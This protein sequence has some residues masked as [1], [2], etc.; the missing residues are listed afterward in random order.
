MIETLEYDEVQQSVENSSAPCKDTCFGNLLPLNM[1]WNALVRW[2][3]VK[4]QGCE[5]KF[6]TYK[7]LVLPAKE[8]YLK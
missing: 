3:S 4:F 1:G 5:L 6:E 8:I 2:V 7:A